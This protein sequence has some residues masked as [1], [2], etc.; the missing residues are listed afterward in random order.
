MAV[1]GRFDVY[2]PDGR[3]ETYSLE[4]DTVSVGRAEGNTIALDTDTISRYHF[5]VTNKDGVVNLTDL[6]S[7]N[8]TYIDGTQLPSNEPYLLDD[9]EEINIGHLRIIYH[10]GSDSPTMP[11]DAIDD[12]TQPSDF[13]FRVTL[14]LSHVDVWPASSSSVEIAV[15]NSTDEETQYQVAITGL[16]DGW[17]KI[18]R[19]IMMIDGYDTA[20]ALLNIKPARRADIPPKDYPV[21]IRVSTMDAPDKFIQVDITVSVKG[22]GGFGVALSPEVLQSDDDLHLYMLNQGNEPLT[23]TIEGFDPT[24][25]LQFN[26]PTST[27]QLSAGQRTQVNGTIQPQKRPLV[28]K[29][30]DIPF[31]MVVK[32]KTASAYSAAVPGTVHVEPSLSN[33]MLGTLAGIVIAIVMVLF[34]LLTQTPTPE[35]Q[36]FTLDNNQVAQGTGVELSWSATNAGRYVLEVDRVPVRELES[37]TTSTILDTTELDGMVDVALIAVNGEQTDVVNRSLNVYR[38]VIINSFE[39]DKVE[40]VRNVSGTLVIGWN[41]S[42]S[43]ITDVAIPEGFTSATT[44]GFEEST[45]EAVV[46]GV[47]SGDFD[48]ILTAQ[49]EVGNFFESVIAIT[50]LDPECTPKTDFILNEGPDSLFP[51]AGDVVAD[52][53]VLVLGTDPSRQWM[54]VE[55]A[56]GDV[57]W[58]FND[59]FIC[60]DFNPSQL[61]VLPDAPILPSSTPTLPN[62]PTNIPTQTPTSSR[63]PLPSETPTVMRATSPPPTFT[64]SLTSTPKPNRLYEALFGQN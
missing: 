37:G 33:W 32:A 1:F 31:A 39:T 14:E 29:S 35:I 22:F 58:G 21:A 19:P 23:M 45:G 36:S 13:G 50:T 59:N 18:N 25:Q 42:G 26:L 17:A 41:V 4:G 38:P 49:D 44:T 9:V 60:E 12:T 54:K 30:I 53:P 62:T 51:Q 64:S 47:P 46:I 57:G 27:V 34:V 61:V 48:L 55:L 43:V 56:N 8:G 15:T 28:G 10:P 20:Y 40:M 52:V 16:P 63:T 2:F 24:N 11:V 7:A 6:D 3:V 5:S